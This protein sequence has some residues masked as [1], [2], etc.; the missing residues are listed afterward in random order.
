[1]HDFLSWISTVDSRKLVRYSDEKK[2]IPEKNK[3]D[4]HGWV[5]SGPDRHQTGG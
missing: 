3:I 1:M 2:D 4:S 5:P